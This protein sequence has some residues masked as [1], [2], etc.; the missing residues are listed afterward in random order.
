MGEPHGSP[1]LFN[2]FNQ[3]MF[4]LSYKN[5]SEFKKSLTVIPNPSEMAMSVFKLTPFALPFIM[6]FIVSCDKQAFCSS[7]Y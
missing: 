1:I 4:K 5:R 6:L 3:S 7:L 2:T